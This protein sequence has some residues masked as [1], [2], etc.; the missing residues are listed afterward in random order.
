MATSCHQDCGDGCE[1]FV[2]VKAVV[3]FD[4]VHTRQPVIQQKEVGGTVPHELQRRM[5]I[6]CRD[7]TVGRLLPTSLYKHWANGRIL[8]VEEDRFRCLLR[9][10]R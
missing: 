3:E 4:A 10:S 7:R 2:D 9:F 8:L 6:S 5:A 1:G